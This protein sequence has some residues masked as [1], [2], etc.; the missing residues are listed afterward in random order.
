MTRALFF[1]NIGGAVQ[2]FDEGESWSFSPA[3]R[4]HH[5]FIYVACD[6][7]RIKYPSGKTVC[8]KKGNFIYIPK[9]LRYSISFHGTEKNR[10]SDLQVVFNVQDINGNEY[11]IADEAVLILEQTPNKVIENML[12]IT[13]STLNLLYPTFPIRKEFF[14]MLDTV[15]NHLWLPELS[16]SGKS[17]VFPAV[18]YLDKH[19]CDNVSITSLAK[20][21]MLNESTF[22]REFKAATG[23]SPVQYKAEMRINKAKELIRCTP[24]IPTAALVEQLGFYDASYFYKTFYKTT[25]MTLK[26]YRDKFKGQ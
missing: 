23:K 6:F 8:F 14:A 5:G 26:E 2:T 21:C 20:M 11:Y 25:G 19:L 17:K 24:E 15:S 10:Y 22:R 4:P 9:K 1:Y 16:T 13:D 18:C 7:V 3:P 12:S